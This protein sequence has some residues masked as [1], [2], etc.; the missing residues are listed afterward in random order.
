MPPT[1]CDPMDC[2]PS[3]PMDCTFQAPLSMG[4][5]KQEYWSESPLPSPGDLPDP[6]IE[7]VSVASP[8]LADRFLTTEPPERPQSINSGNI[9][10]GNLF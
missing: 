9:S 8:T 7:P 2:I 6:G 3:D 10:M 5:L 1:L 4:F